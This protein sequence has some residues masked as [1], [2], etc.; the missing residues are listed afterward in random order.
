MIHAHVRDGLG[1]FGYK[2]SDGSSENPL[3]YAENNTYNVLV[4]DAN[5]CYTLLEDIIVDSS[6]NCIEIVNT[7]SPNGDGINDFWNI[8]LS[9]IPSISSATL[10]IF[11]K[12]GNQ[13]EKIQSF[14]IF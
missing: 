1:Y 12:W 3:T 6:L 7:F 5:E 10:V 2:W 11:N 8:N 9:N 4:S 14:S 13:I